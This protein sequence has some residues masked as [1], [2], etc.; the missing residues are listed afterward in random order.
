MPHVYG[1]DQEQGSWEGPPHKAE[2]KHKTQISTI[3]LQIVPYK[4]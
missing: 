4:A 1:E 2:A 3:S